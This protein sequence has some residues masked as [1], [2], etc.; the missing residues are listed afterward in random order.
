LIGPRN[1]GTIYQWELGWYVSAI[2]VAKS[3]GH[4]EMFDLL[5][6]RSP[7]EERLLNACWLHDEATVNSL[8][9][10]DSNL[11]AKLPIAGRRHT[12][13]TPRET[14]TRLQSA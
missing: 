12:W 4:Q 9:A 13:R 14:M 5:M 7:A 8:L 10:Q 3:F 1:G 6:G 11:A 2:Q